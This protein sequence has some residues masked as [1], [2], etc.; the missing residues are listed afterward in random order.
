MSFF[1]KLPVK[2]VNR[3]TPFIELVKTSGLTSEILQSREIAPVIRNENIQ[4]GNHPRRVVFWVDEG[5]F[6]DAQ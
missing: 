6:S 4:L 2:H 3:S 1:R 5:K